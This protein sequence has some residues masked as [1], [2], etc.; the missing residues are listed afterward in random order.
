M[1]T[2]ISPVLFL[3]QNNL[4]TSYGNLNGEPTCHAVKPVNRLKD[5]RCKLCSSSYSFEIVIDLDSFVSNFDW[6]IN[7]NNLRF[8]TPLSKQ[9]QIQHQIFFETFKCLIGGWISRT[10]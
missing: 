2:L 3:N 6:P 7:Q 1:K 10:D 9:L 8:S 4:L 5:K